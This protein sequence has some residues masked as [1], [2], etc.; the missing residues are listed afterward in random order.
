MDKSS[1]AS[2]NPIRKEAFMLRFYL[3][4]SFISENIYG[5]RTKKNG[6]ITYW[7]VFP[8]REFISSGHR[9]KYS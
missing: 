3:F 2:L 8:A 9:F 7:K 6:E 4:A 1:F 5:K